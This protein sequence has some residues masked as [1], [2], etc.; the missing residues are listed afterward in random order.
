[1][2]KLLTTE[3]SVATPSYEF[4]LCGNSNGI[5]SHCHTRKYLVLIDR[6]ASTRFFKWMVNDSKKEKEEN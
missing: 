6:A 1:M 5:I 3:T 2:R 4:I